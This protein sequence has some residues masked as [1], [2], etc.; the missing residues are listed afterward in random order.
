MLYHYH[1]HSGNVAC[2]LIGQPIKSSTD[3]H[4]HRLRIRKQFPCLEDEYKF[5]RKRNVME[6]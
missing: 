1:Y 6:T 5:G 4:L 3:I 2:C